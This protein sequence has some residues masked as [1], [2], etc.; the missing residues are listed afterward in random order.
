MKYLSMTTIVQTLT[1]STVHMAGLLRALV[2]IYSLGNNFCN[3]RQVRN[4][5]RLCTSFVFV[6]LVTHEQ[7]FCLLL[8][9]Y[10]NSM[11]ITC[12]DI[13]KHFSFASFVFKIIIV[14]YIHFTIFIDFFVIKYITLLCVNFYFSS[15]LFLM[16]QVRENWL[17]HYFI[18]KFV[19]IGK[20][21][22]QWVFYNIYTY[23]KIPFLNTFYLFFY[24]TIL[25][26]KELILI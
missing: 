8:K 9:K 16:V 15:V 5:L 6:N 4:G 23:R 19:W 3:I 1:C 7:S 25:Q 21:T 24:L 20:K 10:M 12:H 22:K 17:N 26:V 13:V 2:S 11:F 18:S 14:T